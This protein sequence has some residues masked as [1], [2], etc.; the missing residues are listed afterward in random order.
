MTMRLDL[1]EI[2]NL[3][4]SLY[5]EILPGF[6][7]YLPVLI[8]TKIGMPRAG[9]GRAGNAGRAGKVAYYR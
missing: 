9:G 4:L 8:T 1:K 3:K 6:V 5:F 7:K 2:Q